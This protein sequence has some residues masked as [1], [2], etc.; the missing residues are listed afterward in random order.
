M[1]R[2]YSTRASELDEFLTVLADQY[3]RAVLSYFQ[4]TSAD[5]A[6][7]DALASELST[8]ANKDA[9]QV[10]VQLHHSTLP[11]LESVDVLEYDQQ[12]RSVRY[13]GHAGLE[14]LLAAVTDR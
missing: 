6:T 3:R 5:V 12:S 13:H 2:K 14:T 1:E 7:I 11:H 9:D 4:D 8:G 10:T